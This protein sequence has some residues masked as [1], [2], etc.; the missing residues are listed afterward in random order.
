MQALSFRRLVPLVV[1]LLP[2]LLGACASAP[3]AADVPAAAAPADPLARLLRMAEGS[4]AAGRAEAA[5]AILERAEA[6][7]PG[8]PGVLR[9]QAAALLA[10]GR[11]AAAADRWRRLLRERPGTWPD[12]LGYARSLVASGQARLAVDHLQSVESRFAA[13]PAWWNALGIARIHAGDPRG[14]VAAFGEALIRARD[15]PA[16][17]NNL[18]LALALA[19][20]TGRARELLRPL[21]E[22]LQSRPVFRHNL[23]LVEVL[24]GR[25]AAARRILRIDLP[26]ADV[27]RDLARL[28]ALAD[29][30]PGDPAP[31]ELAQVPSPVALSAEGP[32]AAPG[33]RAGVPAN[34]GPHPDVDASPGKAPEKAEAREERSEAAGSVYRSA[35]AGRGVRGTDGAAGIPPATPDDVG[36]ERVAIRPQAAAG[37][38]PL[39]AA[40]AAGRPVPLTTPAL[41][42]PLEALAFEATD[43]GRGRLP[44]G[45]WVLR[46]GMAPDGTTAGRRFAELVRRFPRELGGLHRL[47]DP[48]PGP[49]PLLAGPLASREEAEDRCARLR[50]A[51]VECT[52]LRL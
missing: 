13:L 34:A 33:P 45:E 46:L 40:T 37:Q 43:V 7:T 12:H 22:G 49:Q 8:D 6:L 4:L 21:A 25:P 29:R 11:P 18:A 52:P 3:P 2:L 39:R 28:L 20:E 30:R 26:D 24:A 51:G 47:A 17:A 23:A 5:L 1:L 48:D 19:G 36:R 44:L 32:S 35:E 16:Y 10:A 31:T 27:D 50:A 42:P 38:L 41:A 15:H 9:L 14:A